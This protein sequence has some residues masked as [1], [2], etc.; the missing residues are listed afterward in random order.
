[1]LE[2]EGSFAIMKTLTCPQCGAPVHGAMGPSYQCPFCQY[3]SQQDAPAQP[4]A[5]QFVIVQTAPEPPRS[6]PSFVQPPPRARPRVGCG[7]FPALLPFVI[8]SIVMVATFHEQ[9]QNLTGIGAW[10]GDEPLVC[11]GNETIDVD[12]VTA[13][14]TQGSAVVARGNCHVTLKNCTLKAVTGIEASGNAHVTVKGGSVQGMGIAI[15][16]SGNATVDL[17]GNVKTTGP[18]RHSNNAHVTGN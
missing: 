4:P 14:F 16:A 12:G 3:V 13:T 9:L 15:D 5:P 17:L 7:I 11:A 1:M 18:V 10:D 8:V 2:Q 6:M